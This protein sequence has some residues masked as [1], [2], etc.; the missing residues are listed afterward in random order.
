M[1]IDAQP[2]AFGGEWRS[3]HSTAPIQTAPEAV[4]MLGHNTVVE[5]ELTS[6]AKWQ[7]HRGRTLGRDTVERLH[8]DTKYRKWMREYV[9]ELKKGGP[10][11][12]E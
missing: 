11:R 7:H 5:L 12:R 4:L 10:D 9:F 8:R 3:G 1:Q 6:G 2:K